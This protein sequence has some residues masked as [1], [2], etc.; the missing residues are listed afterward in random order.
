MSFH[1]DTIPAE[2]RVRRQWVC[3]KPVR[4]QGRETK[5]P[6]QPGGAPA[7]PN[8]RDTWSSFEEV[9]AAAPTRGGVGYVF[10]V[11]DG[12][13]GVD[14][15]DVLDP[16]TGELHEVAAGIVKRLGSYTEVSPSGCGLHIIV[17]AE[18]NGGR[19]S[20]S[21]TAWGS[22]LAIYDRGRYFCM[23]GQVVS[24][25]AIEARQAELDALH[26]EVFGTAG[27]GGHQSPSEDDF[28]VACRAVERGVL[29][30]EEVARIVLAE[31]ARRRPGDPKLERWDYALRTA[32]AALAHVSAKRN[33]PPASNALAAVSAELGIDA[34]PLVVVE[35]ASDHPDAPL[36]A[37]TR[38]G[39]VLRWERQAE[40]QMRRGLVVPLLAAGITPPAKKCDAERVWHLLVRAATTAERFDAWA[41]ARGWVEGFAAPT[42]AAGVAMEVDLL[43]RAARFLHVAELE[44]LRWSPRDLTPPPVLVDVPSGDH[45][46]RRGDLIRWV[47]H[48]L[49]VTAT[50]GHLHGRLA[51]VGVHA[52]DV[53]A[54]DPDTPREEQRGPAKARCFKWRR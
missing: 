48:E 27:A 14:L 9:A 16:E 3:W 50:E 44:R 49:R 51:E 28:A 4:R 42:I 25:G 30:R 29:D 31:R 34:D 1:P 47:R 53:Q 17:R 15:D 2:L 11:D 37:T 10:A 7:K 33:T 38:S 20:T 19:H 41:E 24:G 8:D 39:V 45:Y 6:V 12:L 35:R 40:L 43:D 26:A 52:V 18:L 22:E 46:V 5:V 23:T 32:D 21:S 36:T 13:V 54:W